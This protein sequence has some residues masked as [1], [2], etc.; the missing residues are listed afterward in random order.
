LKKKYNIKNPFQHKLKGV[1][2]WLYYSVAVF[3]C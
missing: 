3:L 2:D 1:F